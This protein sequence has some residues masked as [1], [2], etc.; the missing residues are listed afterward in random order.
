LREA[1]TRRDAMLFGLGTVVLASSR[2]YEGLVLSAA[3]CVTLLMVNRRGW[4]WIL[5]AAP[6]VATGA[7]VLLYYDFKVTGNPWLPPYVLHDEQYTAVSNFFFIRPKTPP[8]V[9]Q[10][11]EIQALYVD[12]Y[13]EYFRDY[14]RDPWQAQESKLGYLWR[15]YCAGWPLSLALA[16]APFAWGSKRI[17]W[18]LILLAL[19]MLGLAPLTGLFPHYAAP[20]AGL[21]IVVQMGGLHALRYWNP[22]GRPTGSLLARVAMLA[23]I[24][25]FARDLIERPRQYPSGEAQF[26]SLR[27][28]WI[29]QLK[30]EPGQHMVLVRYTSSHDPNT[31]YVANGADFDEE[32][33][34]WARS[35][36]AEADRKL[37]EYFHD[38]QIW[39][40]EGDAPTARLVC[41]AHCGNYVI[42]G[43]G[44][45]AQSVSN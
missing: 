44:G 2:P 34:L 23:V 3:A 17:R 41:I 21:L 11:A 43:A 6:V 35:M 40:L 8:P 42:E 31:E 12:R 38:R 4:R 1:A 5:W 26:K 19:F 7:A 24:M 36:G 9:Y 18:A 27:A 28:G 39:L 22:Q 37:I 20:A 16:C 10:H 32:R 15:F 30:A 25:Y 33:I 14:W 13:M 45:T 29:A